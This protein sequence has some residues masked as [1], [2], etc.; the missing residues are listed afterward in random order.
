MIP[1]AA[2]NSHC[3]ASRE[4]LSG[5]MPLSEGLCRL[6]SGPQPCEA[7]SF[8]GLSPLARNPCGKRADVSVAADAARKRRREISGEVLIE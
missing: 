5:V 2:S 7:Q 4:T 3:I 8:G 1:D 6:C